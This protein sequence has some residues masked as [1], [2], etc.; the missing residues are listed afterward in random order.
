MGAVFAVRF[1]RTI[2]DLLRKVVLERGDANWIDVLPKITK[3]NNKGILSSTNVSSIE[4]SSKKN[5]EYADKK[6]LDK[7]KKMKPKNK[8]CDLVRTADLRK[9]FSKGDKTN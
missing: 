6:I 7:R 8:K 5:E 4:A 2:K 9:T 1:D 3:Q